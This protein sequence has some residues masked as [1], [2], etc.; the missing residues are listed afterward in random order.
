MTMVC[1]VDS[2]HDSRAS[3]GIRLA[4]INYV[5]DK[6]LEH[7]SCPWPP[8]PRLCLY[9]LCPS[10]A[11]CAGLRATILVPLSPRM[12][13]CVC[14]LRQKVDK[15]FVASCSKK[16]KHGEGCNPV[17]LNCVQTSSAWAPGLCLCLFVASLWENIYTCSFDLAHDSLRPSL[18]I[19]LARLGLDTAQHTP[20][21][22][23]SGS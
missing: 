4:L 10:M 5:Y 21:V 19:H 9:I 13:E 14:K 7:A 3:L 15:L 6:A 12:A 16:Q 8:F 18:H 1:K 2:T 20:L 23:I 11:V 17:R 22:I